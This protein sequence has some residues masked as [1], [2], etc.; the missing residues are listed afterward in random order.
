V[1]Q[2]AEEPIAVQTEEPTDRPVEHPDIPPAHTRRSMAKHFAGRSDELE[3]DHAEKDP[4][5]YLAGILVTQFDGPSIYRSA[6]HPEENSEDRQEEYLKD[7]PKYRQKE[8]S[9]KHLAARS[10]E[11]PSK[12]AALQHAALQ[13]TAPQQ[14]AP[15][16]TTPQQTTP[17]RSLR[18]LALPA[19]EPEGPVFSLQDEPLMEQAAPQQTAPQR[20]MRSLA[21]PVVE[22]DDTP[23][24]F[25]VDYSPE[26]TAPQQAVRTRDFPVVRAEDYRDDRSARMA[27]DQNARAIPEQNSR[28]AT[29][30]SVRDATDRS[31][32][33]ATD[34]SARKPSG[35]SARAAADPGT[36]RSSDRSTR[37]TSGRSARATTDP[38]ARRSGSRRAQEDRP[39]ASTTEQQ[40]P[41]STGREKGARRKKAPLLLIFGIACFVIAAAIGGSLIYRYTSAAAQYKGFIDIGNIN[42]PMKPDNSNKVDPDI[43]IEDLEGINW[44]ALREIN[45]DIVGWI[46]IPDTVVNYPIVQARDNDFYLVHHADGTYSQVGAIFLDYKNNPAM[47]DL[48]TFIY[49][50]NLI[51]GSMFA[52]LKY[53]RNREFF[54]AHKKVFL[55]TPGMNYELE[56]VACLVCDADDS[57]R[58]FSF[59]G[60][61]DFENYVRMLLSY[62]VLSDIAAGEIPEKIYCFVTCTDTNYAKRTIILAKPV[63]EQVPKGAHTP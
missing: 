22:F 45:P 20:S 40:R 43:E 50:H 4:T 5:E 2:Q 51:D 19:V 25:S 18:S 12:Q 10:E 21:L 55:W 13:Q 47:N 46:A 36:R 23:D 14:T 28:A 38:V 54:D 48:N 59:S 63:N 53:Y 61:A 16:Q 8:D 32:R 33:T 58:Q 34:R 39:A 1:E 49:G 9:A 44:D 15:Q 7:R 24:S 57:I 56:V 3:T 26:R 42:L 52:C 31:T 17:Q 35:R 27:T 37:A 60:R 29:E 41:R 62:K 11:G 6:E 30:H